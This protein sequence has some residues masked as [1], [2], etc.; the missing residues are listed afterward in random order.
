MTH[1][2]SVCLCLFVCQY[3][4]EEVALAFKYL[5]DPKGPD[6]THSRMSGV[7]DEG[8]HRAVGQPRSDSELTRV[9]F[10]VLLQTQTA[11]LRSCKDILAVTDVHMHTHT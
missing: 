4:I 2:S 10:H 5:A 3:T 8:L 11:H 7:K 9:V 6:L 1:V